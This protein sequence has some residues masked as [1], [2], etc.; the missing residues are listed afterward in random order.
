MSSGPVSELSAGSAV[1][2]R[3]AQ[4]LTDGVISI[5]S[6]DALNSATRPSS[7]FPSASVYPCQ[8]ASSTFPPASGLVAAQPDIASMS[9]LAI[10]AP[11]IAFFIGVKPSTMTALSARRTKGVLFIAHTTL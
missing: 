4:G 2:S 1:S 5:S 3:V 10:A 7:T 11:V 8:K 6:C 9:T